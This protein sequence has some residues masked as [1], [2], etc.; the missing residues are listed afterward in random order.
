MKLF[1]ISNYLDTRVPL[2]LQEEYDNCGLLIGDKQ[3]EISSVLICLD[4][5]EQVLE[6]AVKKKH[7]LIISHHP[8]LFRSIKRITESNY[9]EKII[10]KAIKHD[11]AIYAMHTNLD[12][13]YGGVSFEISKKISLKNT[14]ILR[15]KNNVLS[16]L[17]TY[18]PS[19]S[20]SCHRCHFN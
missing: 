18:C 11:I 4:C 19:D 20:T 10:K 17:V 9:V 2:A 5:T 6:E 13:I 12:N 14:S 16:K 8:L 7:N 3:I 1:E 15:P